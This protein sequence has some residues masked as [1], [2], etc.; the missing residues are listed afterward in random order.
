MGYSYGNY[1]MMVFPACSQK[2]STAWSVF[3]DIVWTVDISWTI[4]TKLEIV[5]FARI[6]SCERASEKQA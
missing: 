3:H 1:V 5:L 4:R 2:V 6:F